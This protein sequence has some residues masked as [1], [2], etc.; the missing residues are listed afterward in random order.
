MEFYKNLITVSKMYVI[1]SFFRAIT[2]FARRL[3]LEVKS[4]NLSMRTRRFLA[5]QI[6]KKCPDIILNFAP[7]SQNSHAK[8]KRKYQN[9][10]L[11]IS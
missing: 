9:V 5:L 7:F 8:N 1:S 4:T 6:K 2:F 11:K 10:I 3:R